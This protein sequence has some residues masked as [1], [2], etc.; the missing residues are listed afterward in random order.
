[1]PSQAAGLDF[2]T[3]ILW[4]YMNAQITSLLVSDCTIAKISDFTTAITTSWLVNSNP[5]SKIHGSESTIQWYSTQQ[6][7][8]VC[9]CSIVNKPNPLKQNFIFHILF[10][11]GFGTNKSQQESILI[12]SLL[13]TMPIETV[14][15]PVKRSITTKKQITP[16]A[17]TFFSL[18]KK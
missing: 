16:T 7:H 5:W 15:W 4:A 17:Q 11:Q 12:S 13:S 6:I 3:V 14:N 8:K 1:M 2:M 10:F 9:K 18:W